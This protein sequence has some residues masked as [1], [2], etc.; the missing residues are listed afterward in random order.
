M[1][2]PVRKCTRIVYHVPM[3]EEQSDEKLLRLAARGDQDAARKIYDRHV[4]RILRFLT[5]ILGDAHTAEDI[6]Q[7]T[8]LYLFRR[9]KDFDPEKASLPTYL[10]LIARNLARNELRRRARKPAQ[11]IE[12]LSETLA[13]HRTDAT[14]EDM[15]TVMEKLTE[16]SD[17]DR[18]ILLLRYVQGM[19]PREIAGVLEISAKAVSTR[20]FRAI[21]RLQEIL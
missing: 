7:G 17:D 21:R 15:I 6:L 16:L 5:L 1:G 14:L 10:H 4:P 12:T 13:A 8:F 19:K 3:P 9:A 18:E 20:I 2:A 11:S